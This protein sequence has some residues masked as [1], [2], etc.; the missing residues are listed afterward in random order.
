M[1][2]HKV[3][4]IVYSFDSKAELGLPLQ[5]VKLFSC[6]SAAQLKQDTAQEHEVLTD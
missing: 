3:I 4:D 1:P 2:G 5:F 6:Q